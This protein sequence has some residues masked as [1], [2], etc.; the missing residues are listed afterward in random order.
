MNLSTTNPGNDLWVDYI[1]QNTTWILQDGKWVKDW[2]RLKA[3]TEFKK[4]L[5]DEGIIDKDFL[6]DKNGKKAQQDFVQG[7]TGIYGTGGGIRG[8]YSSAY[9]TL[10]KMCLTRS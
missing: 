3:A 6:T 4:K 9:E 2:D 7:K 5:F 10:K 1:F 8:F